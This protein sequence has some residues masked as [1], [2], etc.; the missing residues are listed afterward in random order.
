MFHALALSTFMDSH[1][2]G[3]IYRFGLSGF[4]ISNLNIK[5]WV[6]AHVG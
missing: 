4:N 1:S 2:K 6:L 5:G 3:K